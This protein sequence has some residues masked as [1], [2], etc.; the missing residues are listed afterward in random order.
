[1]T[2]INWLNGFMGILGL[3]SGYLLRKSQKIDDRRDEIYLKFLPSLN[4]NLSSFEQAKTVFLLDSKI[5]KFTEK[6]EI[7][8]TKLEEQLY[9]SEILFFEQSFQNKLIDFNEDLRNFQSR[10]EEVEDSK[11]TILLLRDS[12]QNKHKFRGVD[13][14]ELLNDAS[15]IQKIIRSKMKKYKLYSNLLII[16]LL[17]FAVTFVSSLFQIK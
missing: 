13:S 1:M 9:S 4:Y 7:I 12:F 8:N 17:L 14:A 11:A 16:T 10:L 15:N 5:H 6:I 2:E 3:I